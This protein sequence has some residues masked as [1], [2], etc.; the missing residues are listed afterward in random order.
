MLPFLRSSKPQKHNIDNYSW[1]FLHIHTCLIT[2]KT[3]L[4]ASYINQIKCFRYNIG[5]QS[6]AILFIVYWQIVCL[7][8]RYNMP[9]SKWENFFWSEVSS[10]DCIFLVLDPALSP[11]P[12]LHRIYEVVVMSVHLFPER[13]MAIKIYFKVKHHK[14]LFA[15]W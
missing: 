3:I 1:T 6:V 5:F 14:S 11:S 9:S 4:L 2:W 13:N 7:R 15:Y 8:F 10:H 12:T